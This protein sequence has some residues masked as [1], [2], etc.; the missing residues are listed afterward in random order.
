[1]SA[2][3]FTGTRYITCGIGNEV[4]VELQTVLWDLIDMDKQK[5]EVLDYLQV[6]KLKPVF[7]NG[8]EVQEII[9]SQEQPS[10]KKTITIQI[11]TPITAKIF[12]IDDITHVTMLLSDEY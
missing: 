11:K 6:F 8:M 12:V 4:P 7:E 1:M 5:G 9:H 10:R 3:T 2:S